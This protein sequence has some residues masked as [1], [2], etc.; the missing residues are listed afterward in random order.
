MW[1]RR[2]FEPTQRM[3]SMTGNAVTN[4]VTKVPA[5]RLTETPAERL[6]DIVLAAAMAT[7]LNS[8]ACPRIS[9]TKSSKS[10]TA[11]TEDTEGTPPVALIAAPI[12][13]AT[14]SM[15]TTGAQVPDCSSAQITLYGQMPLSDFP[16]P[17]RFPWR[18]PWRLPSSGAPHPACESDIR[19]LVKPLFP[20]DSQSL[21]CS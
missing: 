17:R 4:A 12:S 18:F 1:A 2:I 19:V 11:G 15:G 3:Q 5:E 20:P 9:G 6:I 10:G 14:G 13:G 16:T 7:N 8:G 21:A